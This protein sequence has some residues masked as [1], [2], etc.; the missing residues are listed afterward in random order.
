MS[1]SKP[2]TCGECPAGKPLEK[3]FVYTAH[4]HNCGVSGSGP[5]AN[6]HRCC[7]WL[8]LIDA[9]TLCPIGMEHMKAIAEAYALRGERP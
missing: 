8:G 3:G 2:L 6:D 7:V 4:G 9:N 5:W 1:E